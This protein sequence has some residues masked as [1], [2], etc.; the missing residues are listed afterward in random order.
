MGILERGGP[1]RGRYGNF[2]EERGEEEGGYNRN[3]RQHYGDREGGAS[4][5]NRGGGGAGAGGGER[6]N[7]Y[8]GN[9]G[10]NHQRGGAAG[11]YDND[12]RNVTDTLSQLS[13]E[14]ECFRLFIVGF[15]EE[16]EGA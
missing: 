2:N 15:W 5:Y 13:I 4:N 3:N 16:R 6:F 9:R 10:G 11:G 7:N 8:G 12:R 1:N 14:G